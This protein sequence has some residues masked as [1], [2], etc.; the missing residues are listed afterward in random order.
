[1]NNK[2]VG[3]LIQRLKQLKVEEPIVLRYLK[4]A[5]RIK[6][7]QTD[8]LHIGGIAFGDR[9]KITNRVNNPKGRNVT[10]ADRLATV[11]CPDKKK[12]NFTTYN[13]TETWRLPRNL[14]KIS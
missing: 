2:A 6:T 3:Q 9:V 12:I 10:N 8:R 1:M 14:D 13:G 11:T 7:G 4:K 5:R